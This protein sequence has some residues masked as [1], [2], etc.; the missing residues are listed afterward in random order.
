MVYKLCFALLTDVD[1]AQLTDDQYSYQHLKA[2]GNHNHLYADPWNPYHVWFVDAGWHVKQAHV[3]QV[4][5]PI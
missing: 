5:W 2:F 4:C 1:V 3:D